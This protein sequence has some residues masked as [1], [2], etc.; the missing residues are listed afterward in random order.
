MLYKIINDDM[1]SVRNEEKLQKQK[2]NFRCIFF[3]E[4]NS[5]NRNC[6][7]KKFLNFMSYIIYSLL[8]FV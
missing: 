8:I 6:K 2:K 5:N 3:K 7:K 1:R 4:L